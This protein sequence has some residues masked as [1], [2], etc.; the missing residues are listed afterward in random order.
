MDKCRSIILL[1]RQLHVA[2]LICSDLFLERY[3]HMCHMC[4]SRC[5]TVD[6]C[7]YHEPT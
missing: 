7:V 4:H 1:V 2:S 5:A 3:I 6:V